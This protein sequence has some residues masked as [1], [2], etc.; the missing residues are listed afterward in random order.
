M[1]NPKLSI[2]QRK[3]VNQDQIFR[4][5]DITSEYV[6]NYPLSKIMS[7]FKTL[8]NV[9]GRQ[10]D[11]IEIDLKTFLLNTALSD[12]PQRMYYS[13]TADF[14]HFFILHTQEYHLF[15]FRCFGKFIHHKPHERDKFILHDSCELTSLYLLTE[16]GC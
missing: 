7:E 9:N 4:H 15:C 10:A 6:Y 16:S 14:W 13:Q 8:Y 5:R 11:K 2:A 1:D 12:S 3:I